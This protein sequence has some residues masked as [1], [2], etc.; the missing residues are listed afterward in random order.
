MSDRSCWWFVSDLHLDGRAADVRDVGTRFPGFVRNVVI[1]YDCPFRHLVLLGDIVEVDGYGNGQAGESTALAQLDQVAARF[2]EVFASLRACADA[3]VVVHM[4]CG[5][6]DGALARP[7]VWARFRELVLGQ[8]AGQ[9]DGQGLRLHPWFLHVPG[10]IYAEHGHQ[11]HDLNRIPLVPSADQRR[12]GVAER[13]AGEAEYS[14]LV[15][16]AAA[17][18]DLPVDVALALHNV[19]RFTPVS[20]GARTARRVVRRRLG[21]TDP[22]AYMVSAADRIDRIFHDSGRRAFCYVFGHTHREALTA[23]PR[24]RS[25]YANSGTWSTYVAEPPDPNLQRF[26]YLVVSSEGGHNRIRL[27]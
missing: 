10:L 12:T 2:E 16:L 8:S 9:V 27:A 19:S 23:I 13:L 3:G 1:G 4:V 22:D 21:A 5:N 20:A 25:Y 11:H 26:P 7:V 6:H 15:A 14:A 17:E 18:G 24:S